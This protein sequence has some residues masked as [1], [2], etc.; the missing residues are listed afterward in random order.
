MFS[1]L[2]SFLKFQIFNLKNKIKS[3]KLDK[4]KIKIDYFLFMFADKIYYI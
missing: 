2:G 1:K 3:D 4:M